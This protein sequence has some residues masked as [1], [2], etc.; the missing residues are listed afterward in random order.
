MIRKLLTI[1]LAIAIV[2]SSIGYHVISH[3]C[4]WCGGE[5]LEIVSAASHEESEDSCCQHEEDQPTHECDDDAC[6][7]P[8]LLKLD[9]AVAS[10]DGPNQVKAAGTSNLIH[11]LDLLLNVHGGFLK[12]IENSC[13]C[14]IVDPPLRTHATRFIAFRC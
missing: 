12:P 9:H 10:H 1:V 6:C 5:R 2:T 7:L 8:G 4:I 11:Q 14:H 13:I 3:H